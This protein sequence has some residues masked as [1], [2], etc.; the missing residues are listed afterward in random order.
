MERED[1]L[2]PRYCMNTIAEQPTRPN[3]HSSTSRW[4]STRV[5]SGAETSRMMSASASETRYQLVG[6]CMLRVR[7]TTAITSALP[8]R[9][10]TKMTP[11]S[12]DPT[13]R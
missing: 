3:T 5:G 7:V 4:Y 6:V 13:T 11:T 10:T 1:R 2:T 8:T 9:P 12:S